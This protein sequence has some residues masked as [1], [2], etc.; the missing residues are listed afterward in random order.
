MVTVEVLA[1]AVSIA[2]TVGL[3][4]GALLGMF[5]TPVQPRYGRRGD[6]SEPIIPPRGRSGWARLPEG[7]SG[8]AP[9]QEKP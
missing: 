1:M 9:P 8:T 3:V 6:R 2:F 5:T 4:G 7:Q